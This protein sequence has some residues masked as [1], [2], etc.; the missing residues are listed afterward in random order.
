M[1]QALK[2]CSFKPDLTKKL[3]SSKSPKRQPS[4][5]DIK[6]SSRRDKSPLEIEFEKNKEH[7]TFKPDLQKKLVKKNKKATHKPKNMPLKPSLPEKGIPMKEI[8]DLPT[9]FVRAVETS[10]DKE[11]ESEITI[12]PNHQMTRKI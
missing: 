6:H 1:A 11:E 10:P 3:K 4:P 12:S 5:I 2:D 7:C 9:P 8:E